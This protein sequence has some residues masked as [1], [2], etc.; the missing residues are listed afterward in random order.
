MKI[1]FNDYNCIGILGGTFNPVHKGHTMLAD[2]VVE[3]FPEIEQV[4]LMPN[5]LPAYK[6]A[7][8]IISSEHRLNMLKLVT[9]KLKKTS[10]SNIEILRG[11]I[12][13]TIDTLNQ[14]ISIN[15]NIKI[16]FVIGADSLYNIEKWRNYEEIFKKCS[17][18]VAKRDCD[19]EDIIC[20]SNQLLSKYPDLR[21]EFLKTQAID[22]SSSQLRKDIKKK[23]IDDKYL[24]SSVLDYIKE[25]KLYG[26]A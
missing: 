21:V 8:H 3:Q 18:I 19:L 16:Y 11:G 5:N 17:I 12:T 20:Y 1:D 9:D 23:I 26:W 15:K 2:E 24:D 25:N 4:L 14:I 10:V 13:Y 7:Y 22:I 6:D